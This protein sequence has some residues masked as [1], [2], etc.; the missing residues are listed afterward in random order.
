MNNK[1]GMGFNMTLNLVR[2][3]FTS[4]FPLISFKYVSA[5]LG[6]E[7]FGKVNYASSI[8]QYFS[9]FAA[10]GISTY[11]I[12]E[13][14]KVRDDKSKCDEL[15]NELFTLNVI[16][17]SI[18]YSILAILLFFSKRLVEYR[19]M[20]VVQAVTIF[21]TTIGTDWI[22]QA[23]EDFIFI[24]FRTVFIQIVSL[25]LILS[26]V[27]HKDDY[28]LYLTITSLGTIATNVMN[29]IYVRRY[30]TI[31]IRIH[32]SIFK[33]LKSVL[34]I[35]FMNLAIS[36]YVSS[37]ITVIGTVGNDSM[38]GI[39][40][41]GSKVYSAMKTIIAAV[42]SV[43][44]PRLSYD[45][46][47]NREH[48]Y[49]NLNCVL[50][51]MSLVLVPIVI[52]IELVP[53]FAILLLSNATYFSAIPTVRVLGLAL[54]P[55]MISTIVNNSILLIHRREKQILMNTVISAFVNLTTNIIFVRR[56]GFVAAAYTTLFSELMVATISIIQSKSTIKKLKIQKIS[57]N[58]SKNI[59]GGIVIVLCYVL[60][61]TILKRSILTYLL[62]AIFS[63]FSYITFE[64]F[65]Q[66][67][68]VCL[69]VDR[70]MGRGHG[71]KE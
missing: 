53:E 51:A 34:L 66:N 3:I 6:Q 18:S 40:S 38:V 20:I 65:V 55:T 29:A 9:I 49:E 56:Y 46:A 48:Y 11:G 59:C 32:P 67:E 31:K 36:V 7:N 61:F 12:R 21:F 69:L 16:S 27:K 19:M 30:T 57:N 64:F 37:D 14:A 22:N 10:L 1:H 39:Y 5:V 4:I 41:V 68:I 17:L 28:L 35:F 52:G 63:A 60:F 23:F 13:C 62:F 43:A 71:N 24:T 54:I 42:I 33:H 58:I 45:S 25:I 2:T 15:A 70:L 50:S 26:L 44:I 8:V 47:N